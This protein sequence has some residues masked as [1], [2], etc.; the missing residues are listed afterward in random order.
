MSTTGQ[1]N[2]ALDSPNTRRKAASVA[3]GYS[4]NCTRTF[5]DAPANAGTANHELVRLIQQN[6]DLQRFVAELL[7]ENQRLREQTIQSG[8]K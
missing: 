3:E 2:S 4:G 8:S 6:S 5:L 7:I 1:E